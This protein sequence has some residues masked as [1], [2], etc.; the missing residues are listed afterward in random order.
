VCWLLRGYTGGER[1]SYTSLLM[2]CVV[3]TDTPHSLARSLR[4]M[5]AGWTCHSPAPACNTHGTHGAHTLVLVCAHTCM[6]LPVEV[7][8]VIERAVAQQ[9]ML[10]VESDEELIDLFT[11]SRG[12]GLIR[13][14]GV[15]HELLEPTIRA[16]R[17][18]SDP[19]FDPTRAATYGDKLEPGRFQLTHSVKLIP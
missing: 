9:S 14:L 5:R 15:R 10:R 12:N 2:N 11:P 4:H 1:S 16:K 17:P 19:G 8:Y 18:G 13:Q 3:R 6:H 7:E